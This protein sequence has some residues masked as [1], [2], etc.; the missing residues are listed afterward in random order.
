MTRFT[1]LWQQNGQYAATEDRRLIGALWPAAAISGMSVSAAGGGMIVNV[2]AG[3]AAIPAPNSTGSLLCASDATEQIELDL[4]GSGGAENRIDLV[5]VALAGAEIGLAGDAGF[6]FQAVHGGFASAPSPPAV[7]AGCLALAQVYIAGGAVA[8]APGNITDVR[9]TRQLAV[10]LP[11]PVGAPLGIIASFNGPA[12][13]TTGQGEF[14]TLVANFPAVAGRAYR[15]TGYAAV[16]VPSGAGRCYMRLVSLGGIV[17]FPFAYGIAPPVKP[18]AQRRS[19]RHR[20]DVGPSAERRQRAAH[21]RAL[22]RRQRV[23]A[24]RSQRDPRAHRGHGH[25]A[26]G[27]RAA[28]V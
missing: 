10:P 14:G 6:E 8:I 27:L 19:V 16:S 24:R 12:V 20:G 23:R 1:P 22:G 7:P 9:P 18:L 28:G 13:P 2:A 3:T 25:L 26:R 11:V 21:A 15:A 4:A 5:V 17:P